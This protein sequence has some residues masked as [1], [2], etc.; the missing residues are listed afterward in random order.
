[1]KILIIN[2]GSS[3][4][5]YQLL[6]MPSEQV[7][8]QG[9]IERIGAKDAIFKYKTDVTDLDEVLDIP[10]HKVGL[11]KI[12]EHL[13]D[14]KIGVIQNADEIEIIGHRVVHGGKT[15]SDTTLINE[16]VKNEIKA[17][18]PLAPLHNPH[19]L[20]GII[21][22]EQIFPKAKLVAVFDTAFHNTIPVVAK[23]YAIPNRFY[24]ENNIQLYGFHGTSH[25]YVTERT[26]E[27]IKK[28]K[29]KIITVHLGNGCS[30]TAVKDGKS[31]DH[32]LGSS[33]IIIALM[34][35]NYG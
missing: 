22:T 18:I 1:M 29:S 27:Y 7:L 19:N 33:S 2:A 32:S 6:E 23:K 31:I 13:L 15:F 20:E 3:S 28:E 17:L 21:L 9:I 4:I 14:S 5:K 35:V 12:A 8:C 11:T 25:K 34:L 30:I 26:I 16:E 24:E 10:S